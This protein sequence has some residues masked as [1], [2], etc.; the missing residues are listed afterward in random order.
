MRWQ[1]A[2]SSHI[3]G[4]KL[5][6]RHYSRRKPGTPRFVPPGRCFTLTTPE[7]DAVWVTHWPFPEYVKHAW[8]GAWV[9]SIFRNES[10]HLSSDLIRD[11]VAATRW[12]WPEVPDLGLITMIDTPKIRSTNPGYCYLNAGFRRLQQTTKGGLRVLQL[13]PDE[14]P[15]ACAPLGI[16]LGIF[17]GDESC[18]APSPPLADP[19]TPESPAR[20]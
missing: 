14:M 3:A 20:A 10:R 1:L 15:P 16:T 7:G 13:L 2:H 4:R 8:A 6:D 5:A 11:A 12:Y 17:T 18:A 9:N 19:A